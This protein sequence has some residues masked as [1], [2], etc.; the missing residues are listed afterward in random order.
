M[1][2]VG[3]LGNDDRVQFDSEALF[4]RRSLSLSINWLSQIV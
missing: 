3:N 1:S 4:V 2:H